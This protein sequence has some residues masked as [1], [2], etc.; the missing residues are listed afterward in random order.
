MPECEVKSTNILLLKMA[1][2]QKIIHSRKKIGY[3]HLRE[4]NKMLPG[5]NTMAVN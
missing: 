5:H 2:K 4:E 3:I 1:E